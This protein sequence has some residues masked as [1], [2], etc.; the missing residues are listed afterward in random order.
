MLETD[1]ACNLQM[2]GSRGPIVDQRE[3]LLI[4]SSDSRLKQG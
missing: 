1:L 2:G 3:G 4:E